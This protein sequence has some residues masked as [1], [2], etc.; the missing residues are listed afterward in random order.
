MKSR[1]GAHRDALNDDRALPLHSVRVNLDSLHERIV[2][3][4]LIFNTSRGHVYQGEQ[5]D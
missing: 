1:G 4:K 3:N 2:R 5:L